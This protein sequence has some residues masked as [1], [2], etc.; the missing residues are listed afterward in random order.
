VAQ[1]FLGNTL[2][3]QYKHSG[4]IRII[5][6]I[7]ETKIKAYYGDSTQQAINKQERNK[8]KPQTS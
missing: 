6:E 2:P 5:G 4:L 7:L 3:P 8:H 1:Y